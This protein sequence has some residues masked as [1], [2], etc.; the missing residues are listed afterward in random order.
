[1]EKALI[2]LTKKLLEIYNC[3]NWWP[4]KYKTKPKKWEVCVG[5]ILTQNTNWRNVEKALYNLYSAKLLDAKR[6]ARVNISK[7]RAC[8]KPAGFYI[9]K[10]AY[11]RN[12]AKLALSFGSVKNF[13]DSVNREDLLSINGI[14]QETA[15]TIL[16]YACN[17]PYFV[18]GAYTKRILARCLMIK[19]NYIELQNIFHLSLP[20]NSGL[21]KN[22]HATFVEHGKFVCKKL[23]KCE[24]CKITKVCNHFLTSNI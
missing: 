18:I 24:E 3:K 13:L 21:Y 23:P 17:K 14:G 6:L 22:L 11:L 2:L 20:K 8:I 5:A 19:G 16:L 10:A 12:L 9:Q 15:D 4:M 1:M 7:I